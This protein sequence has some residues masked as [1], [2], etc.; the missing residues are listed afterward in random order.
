MA[1]DRTSGSSWP[2]RAMW[3]AISVGSAA[4]GAAAVRRERMVKPTTS[5]TRSMADLLT[6]QTVRFSSPAG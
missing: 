6:T 4:G 3:P 5:A 2:S 1:A